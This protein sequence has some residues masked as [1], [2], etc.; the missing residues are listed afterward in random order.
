[1]QQ[2]HALAEHALPER[3][4]A[5]ANVRT[6]RLLSAGCS[7]GEEP[8][9]MAIVVRERMP[10]LAA[11]NVEIRAVDVNRTA[12]ER[13]RR[14]RYS[15]W[16]LRDTPAEL[17]A[18]WFRERG[19]AL[20]VDPAVRQ[21]VSFE[22]SNLA[23]EDV[24][25]WRPGH[26]DVIFCRNVLMYF[27]PEKQREAIR[28]MAHA[29]VPGGF[30]FL[31][32]AETLRGLSHDFELV[33]THGTFYYRRLARLGPPVTDSGEVT[34]PM[35]LSG[36]RP[37][38]IAPPAPPGA[39]WV[40][41][42]RDSA[43]RVDGLS[44]GHATPAARP[45]L[46]DAGDSLRR[47]HLLHAEERY[48][49]A[50]ALVD[51]LPAQLAADARVALLR[52][53][54]LTD[55]GRFADAEAACAALLSDEATRAGAHYLIALCREGEGDRASAREHDL[56]ALYLDP[57]FAMARLHLGLLLR[58]DG[59]AP[60]ARRELEQAL[61]LLERDDAARLALYGGGFKRDALVRLCRA[62]LDA[63][64]EAT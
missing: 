13:A 35:D 5:R 41:A 25:V 26:Y 8:M 44:A 15:A 27:A 33:H 23:S 53:V 45:A 64:K 30:L 12:L 38:R 40:D 55:A 61:F 32:H 21:M 31:G 51:A 60:A 28:R 1:M 19:G 62:Q 36:S 14:G 46:A 3:L 2:F 37:F 20:E 43:E 56:T 16:S 47:A 42:I 49:D 18:R 50:L 7:S 10:E 52:A 6:L 9:S 22:V 58:R 54:L 39:S 17:R 63:C 59:D 29:L 57:G 24:N 11:W 34:V 48:A 4:A